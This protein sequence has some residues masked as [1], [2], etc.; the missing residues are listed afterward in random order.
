MNK[1]SQISLGYMNSLQAVVDELKRLQAMRFILEQRRIVGELDALKRL[2]AGTAA[3]EAR[4][5]GD[6]RVYG[7][8]WVF[9]A[10]HAL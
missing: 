2:Q 10:Q 6:T 8:E 5:K 7:R 4:N 1:L 9:S 3:E